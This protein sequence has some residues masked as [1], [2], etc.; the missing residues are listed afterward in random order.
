MQKKKVNQIQ[1]IQFNW[2]ELK[3]RLNLT[4]LE[5]LTPIHIISYKRN[6]HIYGTGTKVNFPIFYE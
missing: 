6:Q 5:T 2:I 1:P 4:Q 3:N